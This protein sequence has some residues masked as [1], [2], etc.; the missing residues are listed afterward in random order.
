MSVIRQLYLDI[1]GNPVAPPKARSF[2]A[3]VRSVLSGHGKPH[4]T[5]TDNTARRAFQYACAV[6]GI[7]TKHSVNL[8]W[9]TMKLCRFDVAPDGSK[10]VRS[11][12]TDLFQMDIPHWDFVPELVEHHGDVFA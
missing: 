7:E 8:P 3:I 1:E 4:H 12:D 2:K 11:I 10:R 6:K 9:S 5:G